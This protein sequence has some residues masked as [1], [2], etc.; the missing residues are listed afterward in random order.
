MRAL[1]TGWF[2]FLQG[3]ATA[4]D[5][6][7]RDVACSWLRRAGLPFDVAMSPVFD[8]GVDLEAADPQDYSH[9]LFVCGPAH[10]PQVDRLL[11]RFSHCRRIGLN[12]SMIDPGSGAAQFDLLLER[13]SEARVRPDLTLVSSSGRVPV[14]GV[15]RAHEQPEYR[16]GLHDLAHREVDRLLAER[17]L[18][19]VDFDTRVDPR[20]PGSR[21]PAEI[22][23]LIAR[24]DA[25]VT[26]R[27]HGMVLALHNGV[28]A[29]AID[30]VSGGAK[31]RR[32]AEV[33]GWPVIFTA[34]ELDPTALSDALTYCLTSEARRRTKAL[35]RHATELLESVERDF[36]AGIGVEQGGD[37]GSRR[38]RPSS[39]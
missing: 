16:H 17:S 28:P 19:I 31:V 14:V 35:Q 12:V 10:G 30:P 39:D 36:L 38:P 13:D 21:S 4:G 22:E 37:L 5:L 34:D 20:V 3:E 24:M 15:V 2:S 8:E 26:T 27:L 33:L 25:L 18:S 32:Q 1:V 11:R 9:L 6:L 7:A 23:S 29:V